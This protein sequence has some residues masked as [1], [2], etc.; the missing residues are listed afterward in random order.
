MSDAALPAASRLSQR[1]IIAGLV[2]V[3]LLIAAGQIIAVVQSIQSDRSAVPI[4]RHGPLT[5]RI[6]AVLADALGPS[7]R[8]VRRYRVDALIR[9]NGTRL[10]VAWAINNDLSGGTVGDG[11]ATD[12][13]DILHDLAAANIPLAGVQLIGTYAIGG[14]ETTVMRLQANGRVL[15]LLRGVGSDGLDPLSTWPLL[16][17][18]YVAP[19]VEPSSTE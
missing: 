8:G 12:V 5:A 4:P 13:Y 2:L 6:S 15:R 16:R 18:E 10:T 9:R 14:H 1:L 11:A 3:S 17:H 19:A 7:D